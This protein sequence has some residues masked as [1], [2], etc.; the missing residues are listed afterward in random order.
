ME[1]GWKEWVR[2]GWG[3]CGLKNSIGLGWEKQNQNRCSSATCKAKHSLVS[4]ERFFRYQASAGLR[5]LGHKRDKQLICLVVLTDTVEKRLVSFFSMAETA[6][7]SPKHPTHQ[8][9]LLLTPPTSTYYHL[10]LLPRTILY[11]IHPPNSPNLLGPKR[12]STKRF[13]KLFEFE[14]TSLFVSLKTKKKK[15]NFKKQ[16][17]MML[18]LSGHL[19]LFSFLTP[20]ATPSPSWIW[21]RKHIAEVAGTAFWL[22]MTI[23]FRMK[24]IM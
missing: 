15:K 20:P 14:N 11:P 24:L 10:R 1:W 8:S 7:R 18:N 23:H 3:L 19:S 21:K 16:Y 9:I 4:E 22:W 13:P 6:R 12:F 5:K 2:R 17:E